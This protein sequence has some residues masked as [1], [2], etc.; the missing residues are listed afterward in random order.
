MPPGPAWPRVLGET[1]DAGAAVLPIDDR[2]PEPEV[3]RL[4]AR[5]RPAWVTD[6]DGRARA[7]PDAAPVGAGVGL[8]I[9]TSGSS[10]EPRA[11][12][13]THDA[14]AAAV[15]ASVDRLGATSADAWLSCLPL[16][17]IGG[18]LV[19]LRAATIGAPLRFAARLEPGAAFASVV[20]TMVVRAAPQDLAGYRAILVGGAVLEPDL[21][22]PPIVTT[23]GMTE[24]CGGV[25]YD[26]VPLDGTQVR[27]ADGGEVQLRGPTLMRGYRLDPEATAAAFTDD[28]WLRTRDAGEVDGGVLRVRGR[29][30]DAILTGGEVVFPDEVEAALRAHPSVA[31]V[32][33]RGEPDLEWGARVVAYVVPDGDAP[34]LEDLRAHARDRLAPYKLPRA[35]VIVPSIPR[36]TTG[37]VVRSALGRSAR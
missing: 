22:H 8:V 29:L 16:A 32:A 14:V 9:A 35:L 30:D 12:E 34:A 4:L 26:G 7:R 31:D 10:G 15:R 21:A 37:K 33:V 5:A 36:G 1:W 2:L 24:S 19:V 23:Y 11:V 18:L 17:H 3:E 13:L 25:V 27:I 28:G 20:P 6:R